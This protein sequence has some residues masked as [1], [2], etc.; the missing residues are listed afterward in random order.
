[1]SSDIEDAIVNLGAADGHLSSD[2]LLALATDVSNAVDCLHQVG[3]TGTAMAIAHKLGKVET[4]LQDLANVI[5]NAKMEIQGMMIWLQN[6]LGG[7]S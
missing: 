2:M 4:D 3:S 1:M 5:G 7:G 6:L